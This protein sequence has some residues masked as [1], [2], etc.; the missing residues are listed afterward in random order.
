MLYI[1]SLS[2]SLS[3]LAIY[4]YDTAANKYLNTC[5]SARILTLKDLLI[6]L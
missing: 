5:L 2:P 3:L 4:F 1:L 6:C